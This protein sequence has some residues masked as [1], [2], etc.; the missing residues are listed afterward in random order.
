MG[1]Q[2]DLF[3]YSWLGCWGVRDESPRRSLRVLHMSI[4]S[5][6]SS[7]PGYMDHV[8]SIEKVVGGRD[9]LTLATSILPQTLMTRSKR[10]F[11]SPRR[12]KEL[13]K[14]APARNN[15]THPYLH[16]SPLLP[17][18]WWCWRA[19]SIS[20]NPKRV[21]ISFRDHAKYQH[22][23]SQCARAAFAQVRF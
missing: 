22:H 14:P 7:Y 12:T 2:T 19:Q 15:V 18:T 3:R 11:I 10:L 21:Q 17:S 9:G 16:S 8:I 20:I 6:I 5:E 4:R 13:L 23:N 1:Q